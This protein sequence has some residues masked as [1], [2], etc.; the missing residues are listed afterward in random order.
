MSV[1]L[2]LL[3]LDERERPG[4][5]HRLQTQTISCLLR[6]CPRIMVSA[7]RSAEILPWAE[8]PRRY[9]PEE[10]AEVEGWRVTALC[11]R[12]PSDWVAVYML[13]L[14]LAAEYMRR[15]GRTHASADTMIWIASQTS[16]AAMGSSQARNG[17]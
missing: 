6:Q 3:S 12:S 11:R 16:S 8:S 7:L 4:V 10:L 1:F 17:E 5:V 14:L 2:D 15:R 9:L 13:G